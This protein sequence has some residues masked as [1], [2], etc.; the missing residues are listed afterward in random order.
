MM[1]FYIMSLSTIETCFW[2]SCTEF[3][4]HVRWTTP[5]PSSSCPPE[6]ILGEKVEGT[7]LRFY[8]MGLLVGVG[9]REFWDLG[10]GARA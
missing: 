3:V 10:F 7:V 1:D 6:I 2:L 9:P 8:L 4:P 5:C